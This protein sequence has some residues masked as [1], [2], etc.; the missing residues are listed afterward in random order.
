[1]ID[2]ADNSTGDLINAGVVGYARVSTADQKLDAQID[3]LQKAGV[4]RVFRD[5]AS[6]AN[7][8]RPG[9]AEAMKYLRKGDTLL[10]WKLDR[11]GRSLPHLVET[12]TKLELKGVGFKSL[13]EN[14]DTTTTSGKLV[15]HLF[16]ALADFERDLI[17]ERTCAGLATARAKGRRGGRRRVMTP[18]KLATA[19]KLIKEKNLTVREAAG[20]IKVSKSTLYAALKE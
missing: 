17:R 1:M 15:F 3:A 8:A 11:L 18:K 13:T 4:G 5:V 12:I 2:E 16:A 14:I 6:G 9:L 10:V 19:K 20:R 7:Q